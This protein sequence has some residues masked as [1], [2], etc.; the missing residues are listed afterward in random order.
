MTKTC[1]KY[2]LS[3]LLVVTAGSAQSQLVNGNFG[4]GDFTG[5]TLYDTQ[6]YG[7][8]GYYGTGG[9]ALT[10]V[11]PFDTAGTGTPVNS[12][13]FEVGEVSGIIGGGGLGQG[14][15]IYQNVTL[16]AG[17][18]SLSVNMASMSPGNNADGGT[19]ELLIN[20]TAVNTVAI[21]YIGVNQTIRSTLDYSGDIAAGTYQIGV[22]MRRGG[23]TEWPITP[24]Q[25]LSDFELSVTPVP[26]PSCTALCGV[27]LLLLLFVRRGVRIPSRRL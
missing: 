3:A 11:T 4:T 18:L 5:W 17:L 27:A 7:L 19:F 8:F 1:L 12:A 21:G 24:F 15:G 6:G 9:S 14:V 23:G 25:Y 10:Q 2:I 22:E 20:S 26:E 13:E 16:G